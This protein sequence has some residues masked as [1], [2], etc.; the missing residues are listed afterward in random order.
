MYLLAPLGRGGRVGCPGG[1]GVDNGGL[2]WPKEAL[3]AIGADVAATATV[4]FALPEGMA[5]LLVCGGSSR[6]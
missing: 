2:W 1:G 6:W 4:T 3:K 5:R